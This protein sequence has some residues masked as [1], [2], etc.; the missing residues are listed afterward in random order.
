MWAGVAAVNGFMPSDF[1]AV[2][3]PGWSPWNAISG[4]ITG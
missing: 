1:K 4:L 3:H 2:P